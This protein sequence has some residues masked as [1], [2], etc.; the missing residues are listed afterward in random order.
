LTDDENYRKRKCK[1][2][3]KTCYT[4]E[5]EAIENED[6]KKTWIKHYR[7]RKNENRNFED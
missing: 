3:G 4:I 7:R 2:C 6:F 1:D 5:F